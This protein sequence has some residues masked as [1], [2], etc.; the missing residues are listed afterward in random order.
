MEKAG[1]DTTIFKAHLVRGASN[2]AAAEKGVLMADI[3]QT[4]DWSRDSTFKRFYYRPTSNNGYAQIMLQQRERRMVRYYI[5]GPL[6]HVFV[7][8]LA[9]MPCIIV[10]FVSFVLVAFVSFTLM[11]SVACQWRYA[12]CVLAGGLKNYL[13]S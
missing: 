8:M 13:L 1:I 12:I 11:A 2:T 6:A 10:A 5:D 3:L 4:A 7:S 9:F